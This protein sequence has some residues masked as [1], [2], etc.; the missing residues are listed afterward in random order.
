MH[1]SPILE[2]R[3]LENTTKEPVPKSNT[4]IARS[5]VSRARILDSSESLVVLLS[6]YGQMMLNCRAAFTTKPLKRKNDP[7]GRSPT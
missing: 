7:S 4:G 6:P 1:F 5:T 2:G 3:T